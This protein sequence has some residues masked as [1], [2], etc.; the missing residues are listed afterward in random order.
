M[1]KLKVLLVTAVLFTAGFA[2]ADS[3]FEILTANAQ[4]SAISKY[5]VTEAGE[6]RRVLGIKRVES[7]ITN[8]LYEI[9]FGVL[10]PQ[11][12]E[13]HVVAEL[14]EKVTAAR[15]SLPVEAVGTRGEIRQAL[16]NLAVN[17]AS[18]A[19]CK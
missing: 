4:F 17:P 10:N 3:R 7:C 5:A 2:H 11:T 16:S 14:T 8:T 1:G 6:N 18:T 9:S 13:D 19:P 15:P 12:G